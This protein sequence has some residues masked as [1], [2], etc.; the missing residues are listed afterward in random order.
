MHA[1]KPLYRLAVCVCLCV[2]GSALP[3]VAHPEQGQAARFTITN[4]V[5]NPDVQPFT[6]TIGGFGNSL[7]SA[8]SG[9]EPVIFRNRYIA[10]ENAPDRVVAR[11]EDI[12]HWDTYREGMLDGASVRVYRIEYGSFRLVRQDTVVPGGFH[13]SGWQALLPKGSVVAPEQ[14]TYRF[15][16]A[17]WNRPGVPYHFAV[18][19]VDSAGKLSPVSNVV[20]VTRPEKIGGGESNNKLK[21]LKGISGAVGDLPAPRGLKAVIEPD[22]SLRLDWDAA[23]DERVAGYLVYRSDDPPETHRGYYLQLSKTPAEADLHIR[24]G[25]MVIVDKKFYDAS[26]QRYHTHRVWGAPSETQALMPGLVPFFPDE[27]PAKTWQLVRHADATPV[28][29]AGETFLRLQLAAGV[30]VALG[31]YAYAGTGQSWYQ[32]LD[33]QPYRVDVWLRRKGSGKVVFKLLDYFGPGS[34]KVEPIEFSP[35]ADWQR[36]TATFTPPV[37]QP[38]SQPGRIVLEF[39]GPGS[40][41]IDNLRVYRADTP[42]LDYTEPEYAALRQSGM[43]ALRTHGLIKTARRTYD[44]EQLTNPGGVNSLGYGSKAN[45]LPQTLAMMHRAGLRPWLQIEPH[46]DPEEWSGLVEYLTAPYRP[47]HD[48]PETKP[49]AWKRFLQGQV[50]PWTDEFDRIYVELGNE[51]W[52][53]L[54]RP[55]IFEDMTD[56]KTGA[57]YTAGQV[58]GKYQEYVIARLRASPW[59]Q[60]AQLDG[61]VEF[62]LGG[63]AGFAY[64]INAA[65]T[66][67]SSS[68]MTVAAYLGGWDAGENA[69][70]NVPASYLNLLHY[71]TRISPSAEKHAMEVGALNSRTGR[72]LQVGTYEAGPGYAL[73]GLNNARVTPRQAEAQEQVMKSLASGVATLDVFL[74]QAYRGYHLQNFFTFDA[75]D[76]WKSHAPWYRGGQA[77]PAWKTLELVNRHGTGAML[78]TRTIDVPIIDLKT[79][80]RTAKPLASPT[81]AVY[82]TRDKQRVSV[83]V[84]SRRLAGHPDGADH[85]YTPVAIDLPFKSAQTLT[86]YR[87][88]GDASAHNLTADNVTVEK[89][90]LGKRWR[91]KQLVVN[92]ATG[93]D[94]RGLPP[95]SA[96]LY[97]FEDVVEAAQPWSR[98]LI[99]AKQLH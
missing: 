27:D 63:W 92:A 99:R 90:P 98:K 1:D 8:G 87:M 52:N 79:N 83:F 69:L 20:A 11:P 97:V 94:D 41:D 65:S 31:T 45:T 21:V 96:F 4:E 5:V 44:L 32:V 86:L 35:G 19:A 22:N 49:W 74:A 36:F 9:F 77:Y 37:V 67:P 68:H 66:S 70:P 43:Q 54:F 76:Y 71:A 88:T 80:T 95:S 3:A 78:A 58:Y 93:G 16:W 26:R 28:A 46:L 56:A 53:S 85:G 17:E 7:F 40:F 14:T 38:G 13:A 61:K 72:S 6:A 60:A 50:K 23:A 47:G 62:V 55:W 24:A 64:G 42:Y 84:I 48:T 33:T 10:T 34:H 73:S 12:S 29:E 18:R 25:D 51:T 81:V 82:A 15:R 30:P 57:R 2:L 59:W 39:T 91:G 75:G 89:L